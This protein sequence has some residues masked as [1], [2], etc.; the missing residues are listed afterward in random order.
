M[1]EK[2]VLR[3]EQQ[4][5]L[6]VTFHIFRSPAQKSSCVLFTFGDPERKPEKKNCQNTFFVHFH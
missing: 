4:D 3:H 5:S 2:R 1:V 6:T